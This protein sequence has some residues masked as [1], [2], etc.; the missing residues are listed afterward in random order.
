M[1]TGIIEEIGIV[2]SVEPISGGI[3][4][5]ISAPFVAHD[6]KTGDSVCV[7]GICLTAVAIQAG[8]F[9]AEAVG[10]TLSKTTIAAL[11]QKSLVNLERAL[12]LNK[13]LGG[14]IVQG[15]VNGK[16]EI[17]KI[18]RLGENYSVEVSIPAGLMK[19]IIA[20]GSI[21]V[22]GI[23]LTVASVEANGITLSIIPHT[24][25]H[26]TLGFRKAGDEVNI[27]VDLIAKYV[28]KLINAKGVNEKPITEDW[29]RKMGYK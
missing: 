16:G 4:L 20:E 11:T 29:L 15:H 27:E 3:S 1:F 23:S 12:T 19:Y 24:W 9:K 14:H 10:E 17:K 6:L 18:E 21:A 7:N 28:E 25:K 8:L 22:D 26:T 13:P 5:L 2:K